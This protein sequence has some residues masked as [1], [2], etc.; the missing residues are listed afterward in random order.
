MAL[1]P[2]EK[3]ASVEATSNQLRCASRTDSSVV[4]YPDQVGLPFAI[5]W[6][7]NPQNLDQR[8]PRGGVP[9]PSDEN[10][11]LRGFLFL[12]LSETSVGQKTCA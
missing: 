7:G 9:A 12:T 3:E 4:R 2:S 11:F 8:K 10:S 6:T 1:G 5:G